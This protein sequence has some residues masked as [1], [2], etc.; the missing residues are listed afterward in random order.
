MLI[1]QLLTPDHQLS[2]RLP[3][4]KAL[5]QNR[6][7]N[8]ELKISFSIRIKCEKLPQIWLDTRKVSNFITG[9]GIQHKPRN[10]SPPNNEHK[11][12]EQESF[13]L[14]LQN[15]IQ[16]QKPITPIEQESF[17]LQ[18]QNSPK[19][20]KPITTKEQSQTQESFEL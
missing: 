4:R 9:I 7:K 16:T 20:Q 5:N 12:S 1:H 3:H 18:K 13:E 10:Q 2:G 6:F 15:S 19:T 8:E 17:E 14:Q 11:P